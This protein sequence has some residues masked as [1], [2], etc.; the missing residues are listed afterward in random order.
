M[1]AGMERADRNLGAVPGSAEMFARL[2]DS[3]L[4][5]MVLQAVNEHDIACPPFSS[6]VGG[7]VNASQVTTLLA[8]CYARGIYSSQD[9]EAQAA[10]AAAVG[11]INAGTRPNWHLLR[12]FRRDNTSLVLGVLARLME[13]VA[14]KLYRPHNGELPAAWQTGFRAQALERLRASIQTDSVAMDQ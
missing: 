1:K 13:L 14:G 6:G 3:A 8:F 2:D 5:Q 12:R 10:H 4:I 11:Y 7:A 9:I